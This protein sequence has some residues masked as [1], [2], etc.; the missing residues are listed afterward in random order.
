MRRVIVS[1]SKYMQRCQTAISTNWQ[2]SRAGHSQIGG[3]QCPMGGPHSAFS[4]GSLGWRS[5]TIANM[6]SI[7]LGAPNP[8]LAGF[9]ATRARP[10]QRQMKRQI[11]R[12]V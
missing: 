5:S 11:W 2:P 7:F 4:Y 12:N 1:I 6:L 10:H 8:K 3:P 9:C